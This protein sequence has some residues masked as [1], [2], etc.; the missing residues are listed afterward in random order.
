MLHAPCPLPKRKKPPQDFPGAASNLEFVK[1]N[2][3]LDDQ[4]ACHLFI[5]PREGV[6]IGA[7]GK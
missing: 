3:T 2:L 6:D 5:I 1:K 4:F 7:F